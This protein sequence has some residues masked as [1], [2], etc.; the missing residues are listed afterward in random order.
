MTN[1]KE[2]VM[3]VVFFISACMSIVAVV[4]ICLF[5]FGNGIPAIDKI[6]ITKFIFGTTW[7]PSNNLYGI[8]PMIVGSIYVTGGAIIIGVPTGVLCAIF[9]AY[10]CPDGLHKILKPAIDLLA[11]IPSIVY[12][13]FGL[14]LIVP[15]IDSDPTSVIVLAENVVP[16]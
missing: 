4:L 5:M 11:G 6:G 15:I 16:T 8:F 13:F 2:N 14:V 12:G 7:R 9:M 10:F 1:I 3:R